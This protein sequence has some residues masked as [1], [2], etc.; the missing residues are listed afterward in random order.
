M[1]DRRVR[2]VVKRQQAVVK[3]IAFYDVFIDCFIDEGH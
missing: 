1:N 2:L 3:L